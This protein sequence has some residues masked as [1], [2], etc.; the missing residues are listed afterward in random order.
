[1]PEIGEIPGGGRPFG[2][3][4]SV[5]TPHIDAITAQLQ[6]QNAERRAFQQKSALQ[7]DE[8][9]AKELANVRSVDMDAVSKAYGNWKNIT[10]QSLRPNYQSN[11]SLYN[12]IQQEKNAAL[13]HAMNLIN[14]SSEM[15]KAIK[16]MVGERKA[17]PNLY[18]DNFG[19]LVAAY[20]G[21]PMDKLQNSP[22]G[23]LTNPD[24]YRY[25][26]SQTD[27]GK[28]EATASGQPKQTYEKTEKINDLQ[29]RRTPVLFGNSPAQF[30]DN[31]KGQL[32]QH[33]PGRD[34]AAA[35]EAIPDQQ[36][37]AV[38]QAYSQIPPEKWQAMTGDTKPQVIAP[39]DPTN[40]TENYAAYRA[41]VYA[42]NSVPKQGNYK[43]ETNLEAKMGLQQQQRLQMEKQ[44]HI[45]RSAEIFQR[46]NNASALQKQK[47]QL[48]N[49]EN[50]V[51]SVDNIEAGLDNPGQVVGDKTLVQHVQSTLSTWNSQGNTAN[52]Q[53]KLT[54]LPVLGNEQLR[55][56][57][58]GFNEV[59]DQALGSL[60]NAFTYKAKE[61]DDTMKAWDGIEAALK[62]HTTT[63]AQKTEV[64]AKAMNTIN[65][66]NGVPVIISPEDL[67]KAVPL[68]YERN[69]VFKEGNQKVYKVVKPGT[70]EFQDV[71]NEKRN[72]L[73]SSKKPVIQ[74]GEAQPGTK[75]TTEIHSLRQKYSY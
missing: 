74:G 64:L 42:I 41:K 31:M 44:R 60:K 28:V 17:K 27:F 6:A 47:I 52:T 8:M 46:Y 3:I 16:E 15:G 12:G 37:Q 66:K 23:D 24:T 38:D 19:D 65:Q 70:P 39:T 57:V 71:V 54:T 56:G 20:N 22:L 50:G 26:G 35:W 53:T 75:T 59:S 5:D 4:Y 61:G 21:T 49:P 32:A 36:K 9:M 48:T 13:G 18:A 63:P 43:D 69:D 33:I 45:D 14:R 29:T 67:T 68:L 62:S 25:K 72:A 10:M 73:L 34:A 51:P 40:P 2:S 11:P 30:F 55:Q 58:K 1:M 7:T